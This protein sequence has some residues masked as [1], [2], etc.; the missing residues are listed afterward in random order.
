ME[1]IIWMEF[2]IP[3]LSPNIDVKQVQV[4][5]NLSCFEMAMSQ[6]KKWIKDF[7]WL[8]ILTTTS[9]VV[10]ISQEKHGHSSW[11]IAD[12]IFQ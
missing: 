9:D 4:L 8:T 11:R 12:H 1:C 7:L 5:T 3:V 6:P 10:V 2:W